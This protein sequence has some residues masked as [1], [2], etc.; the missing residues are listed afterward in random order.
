M[1]IPNQLTFSSTVKI[2]LE[3]AIS[4]MEP[5]TLRNAVEQGAR[6][7]LFQYIISVVIL[8]FRRNTSIQLVAPGQSPAMKALPYTLFSFLF[9]WWGFPWGLIRTPQVLYH[10]LKGGTDVTDGVLAVLGLPP[11]GNPVPNQHPL[12][13]L[14]RSSG[15]AD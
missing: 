11:V 4:K 9:G 14:P 6:L 13:P 7:V 2:D 8:T 1:P 10:N 12:A 15:S 3:P 5:E